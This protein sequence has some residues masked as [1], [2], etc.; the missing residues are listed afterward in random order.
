MLYKFLAVIAVLRKCLYSH[1]V[2]NTVCQ[3][4][5]GVKKGIPAECPKL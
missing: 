4:Q 1:H 3:K 5:N 2:F